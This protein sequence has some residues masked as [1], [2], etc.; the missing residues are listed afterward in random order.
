MSGYGN[1]GRAESFLWTAFLGLLGFSISFGIVYWI[2]TKDLGLCFV[3]ALAMAGSASAA[4]QEVMSF[5]KNLVPIFQSI[6]DNINGLM[7][8]RDRL[9]QEIDDL[10]DRV[11]DLDSRI[12]ELESRV[13]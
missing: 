6:D 13:G 4:K 1:L 8:E 7:A 3:I 2:G 11:K 12:D 10:G 5:G 9:E